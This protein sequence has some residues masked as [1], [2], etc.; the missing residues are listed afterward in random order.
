MSPA[1]PRSTLSSAPWPSLGLGLLLGLTATLAS[2]NF[3]L[4]ITAPKDD[5]AGSQV[6]DSTPDPDIWYR[7]A[8]GDGYGDPD[9]PL[10]TQSQPSGYVADNTDCDD[11][12]YSSHPGG[13]E[14]CDGADNDCNGTI[15]DAP[16][17]GQVWYSDNDNDTWGDPASPIVA[18]EHPSGTVDNTL[19]CDD[20]NPRE[21]IIADAVSGNS[22]GSGTASDPVLSLQAAIDMANGC[23]LAK[24]GTYRETIDF[25]G[26]SITVA[27]LEGS[28]ATVIDP[29]TSPCSIS[30]PLA[31]VSAVSF[32]SNSNASPAL[33]GFSIR[34]GSG[35][36]FYS[37]TST[38][39]AD[40]AP[41]HEGQNTCTV[42]LYE[43]CGG[44]IRVDGDDPRLVD[45]AIEDNILPDYSQQSSG[46]FTQIWRYSYGGG[47]C[48]QSGVVSLEG[49]SLVQNQADTGGG[50][51]AASG[52]VITLHQAMLHEN[53]ASDGA[54]VYLDGAD[55]SASNSVFACNQADVDGGGVFATGSRTASFTNVSFYGNASSDSGEQ[56]GSQIFQQGT[57]G[58]IQLNNTIVQ[59]TSAT[60]AVYGNGTG[61]FSYNDVYNSSWTGRNYGGSFSAGARDIS[62]D[63]SFDNAHCSTGP[64]SFTLAGSSPAI[65]AGDPDASFNDVDGS[66]NDMGG[67]GGPGG[68]W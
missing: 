40:S 44:G 24:P 1:T 58:T 64:V 19:D 34:G 55:L 18:C 13:S 56:R 14:V 21:P 59:A 60:Y 66:R 22:S 32:T 68:D 43:Y 45:L 63:P 33:Q 39:C 29:G 15:D 61:Q 42:H 62:Q 51:Y 16:L 47:I 12:D 23:V 8:D 36:T 37:S 30:N 67:Y 41:S 65:D 7:D 46:S 48:V 10:R 53:I 28:G 50:I 49:V 27:G 5:T 11:A 26:K 6:P 2:C 17:D 54:G 38:T 31:C 9:Q 20:T 25:G 35:A 4:E 57:G 3:G 52:T